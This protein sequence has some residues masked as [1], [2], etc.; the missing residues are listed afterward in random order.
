MGGQFSGHAFLVMVKFEF[1][2]FWSP[3]QFSSHNLSHFHGSTQALVWCLDR[4]VCAA[5]EN[6]V[7][8]QGTLVRDRIQ[9][10]HSQVSGT[11]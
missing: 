4:E 6:I 9:R 10:L 5:R 3:I 7:N 1:G 8:M 11:I 2:A